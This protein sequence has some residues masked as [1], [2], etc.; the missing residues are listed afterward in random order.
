M[1]AASGTEP[2]PGQGGDAATLAALVSLD[3]LEA[4]LASGH[5]DLA[6]CNARGQTLLSLT[7]DPLVVRRLIDLGLSV[8]DTIRATLRATFMTWS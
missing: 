8:N 2:A 7:R 1:A 6:Y 5:V 3:A 4:A